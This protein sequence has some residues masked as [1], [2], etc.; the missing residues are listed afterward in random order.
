MAVIQTNKSA[1]LYSE[2]NQYTPGGVHTSIRNVDPHLIF[3]TADGAYIYDADGNRYIDY[4]AAFGPFVLGHRHPYVTE[5]VI[6]AIQRTDLFGVGTTD[7]EI[8][9]SEKI[10]RHVPSA[11]MVLFCNSGSEATYHAIRLSRA[12][13]GRRKLIKFQGCYH[14]W[15]DY[16]ARNML[17]APD[18]IGK[19]DPGSAGMMDEAVDNTLVCTFNDLDDV[20]QTFKANPGEIAALIVE[21]I[22]HNIGCVLPQPGFLQGLRELCTQYG[23]LLIFDEVI[24]GFRHDIGGFQKVAG[25]TPD[26]TTMGKAMANGFPIAAVAGKQSLME[27]FNTKPGGDVWFAGTYNGHAVGTAASIATLEMME[28]HNV[29]EYI[30]RLGE[31]MRQGIRDIHQRLGIKAYVAGF[32]SVWT[33]YF[34]ENE[35]RNY[36]DLMQNDAE[37]YV[38]YRRKLLE[39]GIFKLPMNIKRNHISFS[40]TEEDIDYTLQCIE[41]VLKEL[42]ESR[43]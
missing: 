11:D 9:L 24:T 28:R 15:H 33:T 1:M 26:L 13:T 25:I 34:L 12:V 5:K 7:L 2:A 6:E 18:M 43:G 35:P 41:D 20:E 39:R 42:K 36:T 16:V 40:H 38:A 37:L 10:C 17:S 22:Q 29:H 23:A 30:F 31:R 14:G 8:R 4:Q 3:T 32:G 21:P 19:R 27:R